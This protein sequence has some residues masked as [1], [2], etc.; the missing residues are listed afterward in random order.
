MLYNE[1]KKL[2][3]HLAG[4]ITYELT[5]PILIS[6]LN[7]DLFGRTGPAGIFGVYTMSCRSHFSESVNVS[8]FDYEF[9]LF[10]TL[11]IWT[12]TFKYVV[13]VAT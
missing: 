13:G 6:S 12:G 1:M 10:I 7:S 3:G 5:H 9:I 2:S 4:C 8:A 11:E